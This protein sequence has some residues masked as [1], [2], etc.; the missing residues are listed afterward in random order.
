MCIPKNCRT[1]K[2]EGT[3]DCDVLEVVNGTESHGEVDDFEDTS[4][5]DVRHLK[6]SAGS[7]VWSVEGNGSGSLVG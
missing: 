4:E 3:D 2:P 5:E 6:D 7:E 1:A